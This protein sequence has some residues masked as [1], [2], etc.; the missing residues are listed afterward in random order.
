MA[1]DRNDDKN[2]V[3]IMEILG[4]QGRQNCVQGSFNGNSMIF[5][6]VRTAG[7]HS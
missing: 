2:E 6:P 4:H 3:Y 7:A 1:Q 5:V